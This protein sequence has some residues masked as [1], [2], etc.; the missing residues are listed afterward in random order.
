MSKKVSDWPV[1]FYGAAEPRVAHDPPVGRLAPTRNRQMSTRTAWLLSLPSARGPL[2][3]SWSYAN[4]ERWHLVV[5]WGH[6]LTQV[7]SRL[8]CTTTCPGAAWASKK[9]FHCHVALAS[10]MALLSSPNLF[11]FQKTGS[12]MVPVFRRLVLREK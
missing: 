9:L 2:P 8:M 1:R 5:H 4:Q 7:S 6:N 12:K 3:P 11:D 10:S